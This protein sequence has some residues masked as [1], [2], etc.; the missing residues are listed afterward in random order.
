MLYSSDTVSY[1]RRNNWDQQRHQ[2][3]TDSSYDLPLYCCAAC[4][5]TGSEVVAPTVS[6]ASSFSVWREEAFELW[7][8]EW[9]SCYEEG[10]AS[11]ALLKDI[12]NT[13]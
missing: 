7:T 3:I 6:D 1:T 2:A 11:R 10:S 9:G 12:A 5:P 13:W 8:A 4:A